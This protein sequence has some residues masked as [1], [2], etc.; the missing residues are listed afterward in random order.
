MKLVFTLSAGRTGTGFLAELFR[1]NL[2]EATVLHEQLGWRAFGEQTPDVSHL[3]R[4]NNEG[5]SRYVAAFWDRKLAAILASGSDTYV[6][7]SHVLMKAGLVEALLRLPEEH[8][9]HLIS[10]SRAF[11]P[12]LLSYGQRFDFINLGNR[13]L[14]YLDPS[15]RCNLVNPAPLVEHGVM[16][17]RLWYLLEIEARA[18]WYRGRVA[19]RSNIHVHRTE[20]E[21]VTT[22]AGSQVLVRAVA[23]DE[24]TV[25]VPQKVN[26]TP[27]GVNVA[28]GV[29]QR[30][31]GLVDRVDAFD[32]DALV[33]PL[34][35]AGTDPFAP[36]VPVPTP[37]LSDPVPTG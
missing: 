7:T 4:F 33:A 16:G 5:F 34:V 29:Q 22:P 18:A 26:A 25:L 19:D 2:P 23:G 3:V 6:E 35:S 21:T 9:I 11:L 20:L 1:R 32:A 13:Y 36:K 17:I 28:P 15:Y 14:W 24:R 12:T 10:Q 31:Q 37:N 30:L 8:D 27:P